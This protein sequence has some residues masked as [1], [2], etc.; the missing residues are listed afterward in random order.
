MKAINNFPEFPRIKSNENQFEFG[1]GIYFI[2]NLFFRI[3]VKKESPKSPD[4]ESGEYFRDRYS[5]RIQVT[6]NI[7][8]A[9]TRSNTLT[10]R[11]QKGTADGTKRNPAISLQTL[12]SF[13]SCRGHH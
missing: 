5:I 4:G 1:F 6:K 11:H 9:E 12:E 2:R 10:E 7:S 13:K 3:G 8:D